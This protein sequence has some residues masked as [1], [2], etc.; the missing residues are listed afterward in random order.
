M[1]KKEINKQKKQKA[2]KIHLSNLLILIIL[3]SFQA[4]GTLALSAK[5]KLLVLTSYMGWTEQLD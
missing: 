2:L 1:L 5:K 4:I 3:I